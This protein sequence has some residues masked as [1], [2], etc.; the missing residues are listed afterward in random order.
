MTDECSVAEYDSREGTLEGNTGSAVAVAGTTANLVALNKHVGQLAI[1]NCGDSK[2]FGVK[3]GKIAFETTEHNP[4]LEIERFME[5]KERNP[6]TQYMI[7]ECRLSRW[8]VPVG[9]YEYAVSRSLE[10]PFATERGIISDADIKVLPAEAGTTIIIATDGLWEICGTEEVAKYVETMRYKL[11]KSAADISK[12]LCSR[13]IEKGS[14]D[15]VSV[16]V[17]FLG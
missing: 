5:E 6:S 7:P 9:N 11:E 13:A 8:Y 10:G 16:V 12:F 1:L 4:E 14:T 3:A 2:S 17:L 15:N